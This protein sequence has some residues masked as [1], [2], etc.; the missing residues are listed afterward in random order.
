M[1]LNKIKSYTAY[2]IAIVMLVA[3]GGK[4]EDENHHDGHQTIG[5]QLRAK[6]VDSIEYE[7]STEEYLKD[8]QKVLAEIP[9]HEIYIPKRTSMIKSF[10]CANCHSKSLDQLQA[11]TEEEVK[12]AHWNIELKHADAGVM[13]CTTCHNE[14]NIEEL[15]SITGKG[16]SLDHSYKLCGQCHSTQYKEWQGGGHGKRLGGWAPPR[17]ISSCVNCHNPHAPAFASKWPARLNTVKLKEQT[18]E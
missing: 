16:I 4:H 17:V 7:V 2:I 5:Q 12:K 13:E 6:T 14:T 3:C 1:L 18:S 10:P 8:M 15:R 11:A 9:E